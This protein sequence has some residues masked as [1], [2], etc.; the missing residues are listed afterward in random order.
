[1]L[2]EAKTEFI[3]CPLFGTIFKIRPECQRIP[4]KPFD[5]K[6]FRRPQYGLVAQ[7]VQGDYWSYDL[8]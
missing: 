7:I 3:W 6:E 2:V 8:F 5:P 1:M 4:E